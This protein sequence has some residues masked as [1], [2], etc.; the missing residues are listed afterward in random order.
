MPVVARFYDLFHKAMGGNMPN[1]L[2]RLPATHDT[3]TRRS[4]F[5]AVKH[6]MSISG[7]PEETRISYPGINDQQANPGTRIGEDG[8][9]IQYEGSSKVSIIVE[10]LYRESAVIGSPVR[11]P[12]NIPVFVD[13]NLG[14]RLTPINSFTDVRMSVIYRGKSKQEVESWKNDVKVRIA[15]NRGSQLICLDFHY[16]LPPPFFTILKHIHELRENVAGY[17]DDLG[18]YFSK[19]CSDRVRQISPD[20]AD[21]EK[22]IAVVEKQVG[23]VSR[24]D[25]EQPPREERTSDSGVT[26][27]IQFD[28]LY[29]YHQPVMMALNY[30]II[31][32]NQILD[33]KFFGAKAYGLEDGE[34][35]RGI[36]D[37]AMF[38]TVLQ[39]RKSDPIGGIR[40]P[41][42]DEWL[43][44]QVP[45]HTA[46]A[47]NW[48]LAL[49][50]SDTKT[51]LNLKDMG[52]WVIHPALAKFMLHE[53]EHVTALGGSVVYFHLFE[54]QVPI[55]DG[56]LELGEDLVLRSKVSLPLRE[57]HHVRLSF[58]TE[59]SLLSLRALE[60][61]A[62]NGP[63]T[64]LI[65]QSMINELDVEYAANQV[66]VNGQ[67][68][69]FWYIEWFYGILRLRMTPNDPTFDSVY[70]SIRGSVDWPLVQNLS[71]IALREPVQ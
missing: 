54:Q 9:K 60:A 29:S 68:L 69:P 34:T 47:I 5:G 13:N 40:I 38:E 26:W 20:S 28:W 44:K 45:S 48:L 50:P 36:Y 15:D 52:R 4:A 56:K 63:A 21:K 41:D 43:P 32:H 62:D 19:H 55:T 31:V 14:I 61:M 57:Q 2:L 27:A 16:V 23:V 64:L 8:H 33:D 39:P 3:I 11:K 17:G 1:L 70:G 49:S 59:Y 30:P 18:E 22:V 58:I 53:R 25:F 67:Y 24:F 35:L 66:L 7:I 6:L 71:I 51:L 42:Y 65:F 10:E 46:G 12:E 37:Q